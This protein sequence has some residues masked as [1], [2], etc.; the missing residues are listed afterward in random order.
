MSVSDGADA[1]TIAVPVLSIRTFGG[2]SFALRPGPERNGHTPPPAQPLHFETRTT[3][4]LLLYLACQNRAVSRELLAELL[5]PERSQAQASANLRLALHRLRRQLEPFLLITRQSVGLNPHAAI[6]VD[7]VTFQN[8]LAAGQLDRATGLYRGDFLDGFYLDDSPGFEQWALLERERLRTLALA[9]WQQFIEQQ[10]ADG[11]PQAGIASAQRL[12]QLDP[13]H[14]ATHRQLM[15]LL[16]QTGQ[17]GAALAQYET[18]RHL[19]LTELDAPP[20]ETTTALAEQI[21]IGVTGDSAEKVTLSPHQPVAL[22]PLHNLPSQPT[23][24]IG[25][26][27]ELAQIRQ[28]LAQPDCRLLT[29]LG[30]GGIGKTRLAVEAARGLLESPSAPIPNLQTPMPDPLFP[31]GVFFV[32]FAPIGESELVTIVLA[33]SLGLP[34][35]GG[36]LLAQIAVYLQPRQLLLILDNFEQIVEGGATIARLLHAAPGLKVLVTSR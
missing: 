36:D 21:R 15:R 2:V 29:L 25:R 27:A 5:W 32:G 8:H 11:Q 33:R 17:R 30:V 6:D 12:L 10:I 18:L 23:P 19:L 14:E 1:E 31:D 22:S 4:A 28:M 13:L 24:F 35:S 3:Q 34:Q 20:D 9:A 7:A 16:A 26:E